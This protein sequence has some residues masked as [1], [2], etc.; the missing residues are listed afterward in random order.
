MFGKH[1]KLRDAIDNIFSHNEIISVWKEGDD[2]T[3]K[4]IW[5]GEAWRLPQMYWNCR[6]WRI[7]GTV[8]ECI[9]ESDTINIL[10]K[11]E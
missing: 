3:S 8:C 11:G 5:H 2:H 10:L 7:F 4:K 1:M 6:K 9:Y